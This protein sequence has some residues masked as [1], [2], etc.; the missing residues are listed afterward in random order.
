MNNARDL[1]EHKGVVVHNS[2]DNDGTEENDEVLMTIVRER[3]TGAPTTTTN[4]SSSA[5]QNLAQK[6]KEPLAEPVATA[7]TPTKLQQEP[8][9]QKS[10]DAVIN[11]V[12][13]DDL[14]MAIERDR[15]TKY[16]ESFKPKTI[17]QSDH[18]QG[19]VDGLAAG[20]PV[21][22]A[23]VAA[24]EEDEPGAYAVGGI[25][26]QQQRHED[27]Q[28]QDHEA[29]TPEEAPGQ[30]P[31]QHP[32]DSSL[33]VAR[34]VL[35]HSHEGQRLDLPR[36]QELDDG[37][38]QLQDSQ[39]KGRH[40][41]IF[42]VAVVTIAAAV[43][44]AIVTSVRLTQRGSDNDE[45]FTTTA[46]P[47]PTPTSLESYVL[48]LL[49]DYTLKDIQ[50]NNASP[51]ARAYE[52][53]LQ[54]PSLVG[55]Y[56]TSSHL[57]YPKDRILQRFALATFFYA[58][59][60]QEWFNNTHWLSHQIHECFWHATT[61]DNLLSEGIDYFDVAYPNPC[62]ENVTTPGDSGQLEQGQY[63]HI[64]LFDHYLQGTLPRE[65]FLLTYLRSVQMGLNSLSGTIPSDLGNLTTLEF[66][67]FS[68]NDFEGTLPTE[69]L[70]MTNLTAL[71][72]TYSPQI[73][74]TVRIS[75]FVVVRFRL[76]RPGKCNA[77]TTSFPFVL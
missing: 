30:R 45:P 13:I 34:E 10:Q 20:P 23:V 44:V 3:A 16:E 24:L 46:A 35:D 59:N 62:E 7:A 67:D 66:A 68:S 17:A 26:G 63:K 75:I 18:R 57:L 25:D 21:V 52:W 61:F 12:D 28:H 58:T 55:N 37:A 33:A 40:T 9:S 70:T 39:R 50:E 19:V 48:S 15:V 42:I 56:P 53:I 54:D 60:G 41:S 72:L 65:F 64:W 32:H 73:S 69:L 31:D 22:P 11:E 6:G 76:V 29:E 36:A 43:V 51:Q 74:G 38:Q 49:P 4:S 47:T 2:D 71:L 77:E 8:K 14:M 1:Q 5:E 27:V